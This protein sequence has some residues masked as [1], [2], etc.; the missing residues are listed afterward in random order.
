MINKIKEGDFVS[1]NFNNAQIT[2]T[3]R[4]EVIHIPNATGDSWIFEDSKTEKV[5]YVSEGCTITKLEGE[6]S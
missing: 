5:Y 3:S 1:V 2:L 6:K 4:A